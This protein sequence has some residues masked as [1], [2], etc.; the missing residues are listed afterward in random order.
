[1]ITDQARL[2][3]CFLTLSSYP[4]IYNKAYVYCIDEN[5]II[6]IAMYYIIDY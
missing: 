5:N 2:S 4:K 6:K 1:M 3:I